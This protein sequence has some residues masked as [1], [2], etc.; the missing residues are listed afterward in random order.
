LPN[1]DL[2]LYQA[3]RG[4]QEGD[5]DYAEYLMATRSALQIKENYLETLN[6]LNQAII[7]LEYLVGIQ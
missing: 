6:Q 7:R 4:Y 2:I 5:T 1:A 3:K